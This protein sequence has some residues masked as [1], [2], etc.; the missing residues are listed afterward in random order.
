MTAENAGVVAVCEDC[1][2]TVDRTGGEPVKREWIWPDAAA[3]RRFADTHA[4]MLGHTVHLKARF[5][6]NVDISGAPDAD[7]VD[8]DLLLRLGDAAGHEVRQ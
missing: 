5:I 7:A 1:P 4:A 8:D 2:T 6:L 3:A